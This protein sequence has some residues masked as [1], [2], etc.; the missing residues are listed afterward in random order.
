MVPEH[1]RQKGFQSIGVTKDWRRGHIRFFRV[2]KVASFQ[3]IG[4]TKD[5]RLPIKMPESV[6]VQFVVSNQLASPRIGDPYSD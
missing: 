2:S 5:W 6:L 1:L 4:V 3:S